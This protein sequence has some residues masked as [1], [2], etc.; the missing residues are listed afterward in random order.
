M[1]K[2]NDKQLRKTLPTLLTPPHLNLWERGVLRERNEYHQTKFRKNNPTLEQQKF[3]NVVNSL[4]EY[5]EAQEQHW[6]NGNKRNNNI[7]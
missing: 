5:R 4:N 2:V 6:K 7:F 1:A 3:Q